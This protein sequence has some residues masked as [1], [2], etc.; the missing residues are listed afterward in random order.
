VTTAAPRTLST[1]DERREAV[2]VA[3]RRVF[4]LRGL[5]GTPTADIAKAAGISHAYLFRLFPTKTELM[6]AAVRSSNDRI[7]DTFEVAV[8]EA[9]ADGRD[10]LEAMGEAYARLL[11]DRE[12][13]LMQ[14]HS[15]AASPSIPEVREAAQECFARL[16]ELVERTTSATPEEIRLFFAHGMLMNVM[17]AIDE[18]RSDEHWASVLRSKDF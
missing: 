2:L 15:F 18:D 14:L 12:L 6:A 9:A 17:S 16:V 10:P 13:L 3:A 4:G 1:A 7:L 8:R 11:E 5:H